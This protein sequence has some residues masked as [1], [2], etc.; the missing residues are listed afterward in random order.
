MD[1]L[2]SNYLAC[3]TFSEAIFKLFTVVYNVVCLFFQWK[4]RNN[5]Q[6]YLKPTRSK[7]ERL[8]YS[9]KNIIIKYLTPR[10]IYEYV[11]LNIF[12]V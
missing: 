7:I 9:L 11:I 3:V 4:S 1:G 12:C 5:Q 2:S 8:S 10:I 6:F